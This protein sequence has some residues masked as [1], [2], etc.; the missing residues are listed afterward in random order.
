MSGAVGAEAAR[1]RQGDDVTRLLLASSGAT[2]GE[3][4]LDHLIEAILADR[5]SVV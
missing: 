4:Y 1:P 3:G 5:K 2:Y